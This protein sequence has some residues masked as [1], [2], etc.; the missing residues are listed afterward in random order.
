MASALY[1]TG[2]YL[3]LH[4]TWHVEDSAWKA[5]QILRILQRN[6]LQPKKVCE[7]GCGAGGILAELQASLGIRCE[8]RGYE[9]SPQAYALCQERAN[10]NLQF[11]LGDY[12]ND[13]ADDADV[14][15][16][17]DVV[18]HIEDYLGFLKKLRNRAQFTLLHVPL[19]LS[20]QSILRRVPEKVRRSAGHLHYFTK[21]LFLDAMRDCGYDIVDWSYTGAAV[22]TPSRSLVMTLAKWPRKAMFRLNPDLATLT[23]GGYSLLVLAR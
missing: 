13:P 5:A 17:M 18:E 6:H 20:L 22:E 7:I 3:A 23:L 15:L 8:L 14:M 2:E 16:V 1:T 9:V 21:D 11:V 10:Q 12:F 4:P 19:D